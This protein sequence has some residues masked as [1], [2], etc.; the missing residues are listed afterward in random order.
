MH[1]G[2]LYSLFTILLHPLF[3]RAG[4]W[5]SRISIFLAIKYNTD[6]HRYNKDTCMWNRWRFVTYKHFIQNSTW[7]KVSDVSQCT[8]YNWMEARPLEFNWLFFFWLCVIFWWKETV[9]THATKMED[10]ARWTMKWPQ[11][12]L[13]VSSLTYDGSPS[14][15]YNKLGFLALAW[16]Y[17]LNRIFGFLP[18][19]VTFLCFWYEVW[20]LKAHLYL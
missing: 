15:K 14:N 1:V 2:I 10:K 20:K 4:V 11:V 5:F 17:K 12:M 16:L 19:N 7:R 18:E 3:T 9:A 8:V 6:T 13:Y